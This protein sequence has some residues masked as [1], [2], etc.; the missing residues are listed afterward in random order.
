MVR[1]G[2]MV[3]ACLLGCPC[4]LGQRGGEAVGA[5]RPVEAVELK[6]K[7]H[8]AMPPFLAAVMPLRW[9]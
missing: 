8:D 4:D 7:L 3:E 2:D 1:H 6:S 9:K 5:I